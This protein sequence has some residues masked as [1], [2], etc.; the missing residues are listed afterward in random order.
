[1]HTTMC[2]YTYIYIYIYCQQFDSKIAASMLSR[3]VD[4]MTA[5]YDAAYY[6]GYMMTTA[7]ILLMTILK[8]SVN[9]WQVATQYYHIVTTSSCQQMRTQLL[10]FW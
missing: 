4:N 3:V 5:L 9:C 1:M 8:L 10:Q 2:V 7:R 6:Y